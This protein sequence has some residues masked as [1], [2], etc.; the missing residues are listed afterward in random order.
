MGANNSKSL[1][2]SE[3]A[4]KC[5]YEVLGVN[6]NASLEE[7]KKAY[8]KKA[9]LL[10]PD[11]N[12]QRVEEATAEFTLV[13]NSY[14]TLSDPQER[15][16]YDRH[17]SSILKRKGSQNV[18]VPTVED[19]MKYF[20]TDCYSGF[21]DSQNGFYSVYR[22]VF[23]SIEEYENE[24]SQSYSSEKYTSF[25]AMDTPYE[26]SILEFYEK[27]LSFNTSKTFDHI[28]QYDE[29]T[30]DARRY[31]RAASKE[32]QKLREKQ[33][34]EY[35][36]TVRELASF[37]Q[38]RDRRYHKW[39]KEKQLQRQLAERERCRRNLDVAKLKAEEYREPEW[40]Q[41]DAN[42]DKLERL[43]HTVGED[44][45]SDI[46]EVPE[47]Y[48]CAPCKKLF[49]NPKQWENHEK[50]RKHKDRLAELGINENT[51]HEDFDDNLISPNDEEIIVSAFSQINISDQEPDESQSMAP[52]QPESLIIEEKLH[53]EFKT[54]YITTSDSKETSIKKKRRAKK[55]KAI[56]GDISHLCKICKK[57]FDS[58]N[59]LFRHIEAEG[60]AAIQ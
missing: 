2:C 25:G 47:E 10:H 33:K 3:K 59:Q 53:D 48:F 6:E 34:K 35:V 38:K 18:N 57:T 51:F 52:K 22:S 20:S 17:K 49:K 28:Y 56:S 8:K 40:S 39:K 12:H 9:L 14:Q 46:D 32:N 26:P 30:M 7:I 42:E 60:H 37:V 23:D 44:E 27:W 43:L 15:A 16:W 13:Q 31:R 5:H 45:T 58:R 24:D 54:D 55:D 1:R 41:Y 4:P 21:D 36:E 29:Y 19:L 11:R 50:S